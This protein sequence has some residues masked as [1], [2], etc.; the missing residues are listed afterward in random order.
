MMLKIIITIIPVLQTSSFGLMSFYGA[1]NMVNSHQRSLPF[2]LPT[3]PFSANGG[4][5]GWH[6]SF[7]FG[8]CASR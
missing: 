1:N 5:Y 3:A 2:R 6:A 7:P 8:Y 4:E